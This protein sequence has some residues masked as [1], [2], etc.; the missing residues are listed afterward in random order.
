MRAAPLFLIVVE[1]EVRP[2]A[3]GCH[4]FTVLLVTC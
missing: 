1:G 3:G 4:L 2:L